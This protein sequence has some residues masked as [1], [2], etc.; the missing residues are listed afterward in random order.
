MPDTTWHRTYGAYLFDL[1]GTL[2]D[3]VPDIHIALNHT[4]NEHSFEE[5]DISLTRHWIGHGV[6]AL[7]NESLIYHKHSDPVELED[8]VATFLSYYANHL[9]DY[10]EPYS[11]VIETLKELQRRGSK[12]A[13]VTN[14]L[15]ALSLPLLEELKMTGWFETIVC[16]DSAAKPKPASDPVDL[17]LAQLRVARSNALFVGDSETDVKAAHAANIPVVCMRDGY[18]HG[19]DVETLGANA[20]LDKFEELL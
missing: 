8:M 5:V 13:V 2:V 18:N 9:A 15:T 12:L 16:G 14:K 1:D 19:V 17:C 3:T 20:V 4:L 7:V 10:S 11:G 6:R